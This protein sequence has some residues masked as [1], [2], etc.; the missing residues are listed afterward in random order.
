MEG[1]IAYHV[2]VKEEIGMKVKRKCEEC[3]SEMKFNEN[4]DH[5]DCCLNC[6]EWRYFNDVDR[7]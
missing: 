7:N 4:E 6:K 5:V 2:I 3:Y 1:N